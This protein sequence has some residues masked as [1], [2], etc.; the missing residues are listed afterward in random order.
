MQHLR[1][2][3]DKNASPSPDSERHPITCDGRWDNYDNSAKR[4]Q[5]ARKA[6]WYRFF[7]LHYLLPIV[8]DELKQIE[9]KYHF[10][11]E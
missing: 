9:F 5:K 8:G 3:Y 4:E 10:F 11:N 1:Q 6:S 2:I 7:N